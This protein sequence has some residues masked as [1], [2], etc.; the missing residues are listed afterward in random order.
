MV[1]PAS[2][3]HGRPVDKAELNRAADRSGN[4]GLEC[5]TPPIES[6]LMTTCFVAQIGP[7]CLAAADTRIS[8]EGGTGLPSHTWDAADLPFTTESGQAGVIPYRF[9]KIRQLDR[10]WAVMTG[11]F[12][13]GD[14][15]LDL[16]SR[17][18]ASSATHTS[19][20]LAVR[21]PDQI[22]LLELGRDIVLGYDSVLLGT[23]A[24]VDRTGVWVAELDH[25]TGYAVTSLP[26][27]AVSWPTSI[28]TQLQEDAQRAFAA[29]LPVQSDAAGIMQAAAVLIGAARSAPDSSPFI[30][31]GVTWQSITSEYQARYLQ[32]HV[33]EIAAMTP[34][35]IASRWDKLPA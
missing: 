22:A 34:T 31:V 28:P 14:R 20:I 8:A 24:N 33:D 9:R 15:I 7:F 11:N 29:S 5:A 19:Q 18:R 6:R 2:G 3:K 35:E 30:Q 10:G 12:F 13:I 16:L 25:N 27:F 26:N 32:G 17:E 21:A 1:Q 23:P 4:N